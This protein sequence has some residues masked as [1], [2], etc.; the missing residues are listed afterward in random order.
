MA[1]GRS[2]PIRRRLQTSE[3][4]VFAAGDAVAGPS[5]ITDAVGQGRKAAH[6]IDRFLQ[7]LEL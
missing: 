1:R 3:A 2:R 6:M 4:G 5:M 7:G